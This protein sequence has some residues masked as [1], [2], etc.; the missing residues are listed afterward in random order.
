MITNQDFWKKNS[1]SIITPL[2]NKESYIL[3]TISSVFEQEGVSFEIIIIDDGST[4][5]SLN[6]VK[7]IN[8]PRIRIIEQSHK[9]VS[10]ARNRGI[11]EARYE[12]VA[13]LDA[14]DEYKPG[15]LASINTL[16]NQYPEC[17]VAATSYEIVGMDTVNSTQFFSKYPPHWQGM[18]DDYF[19]DML[20]GEPFNTSS[21]V[22]RK[23]LLNK[24]K[25]F[26]ENLHHYE[27]ILTWFSLSLLTNFSYL[28]EPLSIYH[29]E[30]IGSASKQPM[31]IMQTP[32]VDFLLKCSRDRSLP[33]GRRESA[34]DLAAKLQL[35][36]IRKLINKGKRLEALH[37]L[38][39]CRGSNQFKTK[40]NSYFREIVNPFS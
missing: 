40:W 14:D 5:G 28:N 1:F 30:I 10:T 19:A 35:R 37:L 15:F 8:D 2:Y 12:W 38:W 9:G 22:V 34:R 32:M 36:T 6:R 16:I 26:P 39:K 20:W 3:R 29:K 7:R 25:G 33:A 24:V 21:V 31:D 23:D 13:F 27:D 4:D 18:I 17:G 11:K